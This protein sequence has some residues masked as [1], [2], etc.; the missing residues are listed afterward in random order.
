MLNKNIFIKF[1]SVLTCCLATLLCIAQKKNK[2]VEKFYV[3]D[4]NWKGCA[5]DTATYMLYVQQINDTAWQYNYY[6]YLG[7]LLYIE[8]YKSEDSEIP[9]GYFAYF[10][11]KGTLD[12]TGIYLNGF[13][14]G[15]WIFY[16]DSISLKKRFSY[17]NG[18][19][20]NTWDKSKD[21]SQKLPAD[22][23]E[24]EAQFKN[25]SS[26]W[27]KYLENNAN[28][29]PRAQNNNIHGKVLVRFIVNKEGKVE[30]P[31][32]IKSV[33]FSIDKESIRI[34]QESPLWKPG[35]QFGKN[36][37]SYHVQPISF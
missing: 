34:L 6:N 19:M 20:I 1:I 26:G 14:N 16:D 27:K 12:S 24:R 11:Q 13:K 7:P 21:S 36:V 35:F 10:N 18:K 28:Y 17:Q 22:P 9:H 29:P 32:I 5:Q 4:K 15:D 23:N 2:P 8:T 31:Q 37:N 3:F 25:G 30:L 33:E